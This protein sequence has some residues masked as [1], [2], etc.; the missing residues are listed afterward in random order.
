MYVTQGHMYLAV[1]DI[2][3]SWEVEGYHSN[4]VEDLSV[5]GYDGVTG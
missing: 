2:T 1:D 3:A 5:V 4:T